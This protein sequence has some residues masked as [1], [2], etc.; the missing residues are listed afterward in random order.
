MPKIIPDASDVLRKNAMLLQNIRSL[1]PAQTIKEAN[2]CVSTIK[3]FLKL[4][5]TRAWGSSGELENSI[6]AQVLQQGQ[7]TMVGIA[8]TEKMPVYYRIQEYGGN[9][10]DR[11]PKTAKAMHFFGYGEEFFLKHVNG[12]V[13]TAKNYLT[14]GFSFASNRAKVSFLAM[15]NRIMPR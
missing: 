11:V 7:T 15:M 4:T 13:I 8:N 12:F 2:E 1:V 14:N 9:I 10:P 3:R 6:D 5:I